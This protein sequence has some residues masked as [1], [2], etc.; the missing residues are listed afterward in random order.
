MKP[1]CN[2]LMLL[3]SILLTAGPIAALANGLAC[4]FEPLSENVYVINGSN[5]ERCPPQTLLHPVNNPVAII[6]D[7]GVVIVDPGSSEQVGQLVVNRLRLITSR[8]VVAIINTHIHGLYWLGNH[9][10]KMAY[11]QARIYAHRQMI[12]RIEQGEGDYWVS[13]IGGRQ[14]IAEVPTEALDGG[15]ILDLNGVKLSIHH[16][17]HAHTDHDL[18]IEIIKDKILIL[19]GIVVE[20]EV[21]SQ[22]VPQDA[23]FKGQMAATRY[24]I[25]LNMNLYIPGQGYPQGIALPKRSLRFLEALYSGVEHYYSDGLQDFEISDKLKVDLVAFQQWYNFD[26]LGRVIAEMYL[27]VEQEQ[28]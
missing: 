12:Q 28:F 9:A 11:P 4:R 16:P 18:M 15:E 10:L 2:R 27:Q 19:G 7:G 24:A 3:A 20:P 5:V 6:G 17:A 14:T 1:L 26:H 13:A 25:A 22:G 21:P 23:N 8:P